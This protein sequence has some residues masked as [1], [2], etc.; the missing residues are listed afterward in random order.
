[1]VSTARMAMAANFV[2]R[3][4]FKCPAQ[5]CCLALGFAAGL[6][7][8][9]LLLLAPSELELSAGELSGGAGGANFPAAVTLFTTRFAV[10]YSWKLR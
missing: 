6:A 8:L 4:S 10:K 5:A 9:L 1:M 7:L 2:N 3:D